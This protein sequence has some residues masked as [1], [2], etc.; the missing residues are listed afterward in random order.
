MLKDTTLLKQAALVGADWIEAEEDGMPVTNPATG[1]VIG[2][3]PNLGADETRADGSYEPPH[4][5]PK[6][7]FTP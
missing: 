2:H 3:V 5:C 4:R 6:P 1:S 7:H